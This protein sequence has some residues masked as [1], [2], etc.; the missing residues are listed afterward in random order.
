MSLD[1]VFTR[2]AGLD[3][4]KET[5]VACARVFAEGRDKASNQ[6]R[7]FGTMTSD[8]HQL[9]DW[10]RALGVTNVAMES[11]GV[12]WKPIYNVL[13]E[14]FEVLLCN[15]RAVK[16]VPG[17]KTDVKDCEWLAHLLS[18]GL[19]SGSFI[20]PKGQRELRDLTR[21]RAKLRAEHNRTANRL[22][23]WLEDANI[24][25][26]SVASDPLGVSGR[27][28]LRAIIAGQTNPTFLANLAHR[29]LR[30][31][32]PQLERA[33]DGNVTDHV[34]FMLE[35]SLD[36]L[37][38]IERQIDRY[39]TRIAALTGSSPDDDPGSQPSS[40]DAAPDD[41]SGP[42]PADAMPPEPPPAPQSRAV[43]ANETPTTA[44]ASARQS[45]AVRPLEGY[46][47]AIGL[48]T[49]V[50]GIGETTA[51]NILAEIGVDM[52]RFATAA[53]L[54]SWAGICPGN[55][56]SAGKV[57]S[58]KTTK[59]NV[60][61]R[62]TLSHAATTASRKRDSY[63]KTQFHRISRRR[64]KKRAYVAVAHSI[65]TIIHRMLTTGESFRD[66]GANYFDRIENA[67]LVRYH[68]RRLEEL[69][70]TVTAQPAA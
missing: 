36:H 28:M 34:R 68:T 16:N 11:T 17:R 8:L 21:T 13:E 46:T 69:G 60:W 33:L 38:S 45:R 70:L 57:R 49:S 35:T 64:G 37:E 56:E 15:A 55:D 7:T 22:Q 44:N 51:Q 30:G 48:L 58:G 40:N 42:E 63:F 47:A 54:A 6:V 62:R 41:E 61:L 32:I 26:A 52:S 5:V 43:S 2:C 18:C 4:H 67:R 12:Y 65:L 23:K 25:L 19:L 29:R 50:P 20:P 24:K 66:L 14:H 27:A 9:R 53:H 31:K 1:V 10:L 39:T 59:G 3:V